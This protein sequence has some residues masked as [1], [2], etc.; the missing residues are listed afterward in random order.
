MDSPLY[1]SWFIEQAD[2]DA[3]ATIHLIQ[4]SSP[5]HEALEFATVSKP[6]GSLTVICGENHHRVVRQLRLIQG[7]QQLPHQRVNVGDGGKIT[8][9]NLPL[10]NKF[11]KGTKVSCSLLRCQF[12]QP[13][14]RLEGEFFFFR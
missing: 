4:E 3:R 8:L 2:L 1:T 12:K 6:R 5:E 14:T 13:L 7:I 11:A 10:Q 9:T